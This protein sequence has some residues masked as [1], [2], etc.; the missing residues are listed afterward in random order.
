MTWHIANTTVRTPYRLRAVLEALQASRL[1]GDL[2]GPVNEQ[3]F[4]DLLHDQGLVNVAR[5]QWS[6]GHDRSDLG[7]KWRVALSQL[8]F[9]AGHLTR[10]H[11]QGVDPRLEPIVE[12]I[13]GLTGRP[14]EVTPAGQLLLDSGDMVSQ[15]ESFLRALAAYRIPSILEPRYKHR[16]FSPLHFTLDVFRQLAD[17]N[18]EPF[19]SFEEMALIVQRSTPEDGAGRVAERIRE[20]RESRRSVGVPLQQFYRQAYRAAV[21]ED[22]PN[23]TSQR[24]NS[25]VNTLDDYADLNLRYLKATGLFK[26]RGRGITLSPERTEIIQHLTNEQL[27]VVGGESYLPQLWRGATL[28]TDD[29]QIAVAVTRSYE[30][31]I[32]QRG[33]A[34]EP[35]DIASLDDE[36]LQ[37][38]RHQLEAQLQRFNEEDF[39]D[40]QMDEVEEIVGYMDAIMARGRSTLADGTIISIPRSDIS[41][42]LEWAIWRAFLAIDSLENEPWEARR[43]EIDQDLLPIGHAPAGGPDMSFIFEDAVVVVEV[44]LTSSSRQEAA[45]GEP[46]RRH[47]ANY[48][49][50]NTTAKPVYGLFIAPQVDTN[51]AH[52]FRSGDWYTGNDNKINVHIVP[53]QLSD[54][55]DFFQA[56]LV[57][58]PKAPRELRNLLME[59]RMEAN[60]D[61]P[62][63]K[64]T[65]SELTRRA[66]DVLCDPHREV[67][68]V[69][70]QPREGRLL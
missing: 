42:Y 55:R 36:H 50:S 38:F 35:V 68:G 10:G 29:R 67:A 28:P 57:D 48:V 15:Q 37:I 45:E 17:P 46:V 56:L 4:A 51:T 61:A 18:L 59:C 22:D 54:F 64:K 27:T 40:N 43:F 39:A 41:V 70:L 25:R 47:V 49:E 20:M 13:P 62:I 26:A 5:R 63:W 33:A 30:Q 53:M 24:V 65:I 2:L 60:Q 44:T 52:T 23:V 19:I 69:G 3:A 8:G 32:R 6:M 7:R 16:Q 1:H 11:R 14:Y 34:V 9:L 12:G 66:V 21:L 58:R 31:T